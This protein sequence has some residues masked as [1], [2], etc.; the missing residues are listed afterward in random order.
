MRMTD[1]RIVDAPEIPTN[2]ITGQEKLPTGGSGNYSI[3]LDSVAD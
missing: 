1:L 3:I 2:S